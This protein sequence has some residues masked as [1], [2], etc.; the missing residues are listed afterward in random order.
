MCQVHAEFITYLDQLQGTLHAILQFYWEIYDRQ[1]FSGML[2]ENRNVNMFDKLSMAISGEGIYI[3][4]Y[5]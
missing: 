1:L 5:I 3:Y 4:I 2:T